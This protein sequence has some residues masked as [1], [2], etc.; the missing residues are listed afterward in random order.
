MTAPDGREALRRRVRRRLL[1]TTVVLVVLATGGVV[2]A[3]GVATSPRSAPK[4]A[5]PPPATAKIV[6]TDLVDQVKVDGTV[7]HGTA[8]ALAGRKAGTLTWLPEQGKVIG[9]GESL[10]AVDAVG[11]KLLLGTTPLYR[12]IRAGVP[13]GPDVTV[14][15]ENLVALGHKDAG[16]PDGEFGAKTERALKKWQKAAGL[17]QTGTL[18]PGDALVLP[19]A[20]RVD[21]VTAQLG[22]A[23][24][25]EL[26]KVTG[27]GRLVTAKIDQARRAYV[28]VGAKVEVVLPGSR[29]VPGKVLSVATGTGKEQENDLVAVIG[30]DDPA[31][32]P[33]SGQ[34]S[35]VLSGARRDGVLAVPVRA[36]VAPAGGG[37]AV[38]VVRDGRRDL[39]RVEPGMFASG[40]VEVSGEGLAE[41]AEVVIAS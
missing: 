39:I 32:V 40:L 1:V 21:A 13:P 6:K 34:V 18:G 17:P 35:V 24:E 33:E 5:P 23:A 8:T 37:Y 15:Q 19:A 25:G 41:G 28:A 7:G 38:E 20:V 11:V 22:A 10:Y 12:E 3:T 36:L 31:A 14:L 27:T 2:L 26:M 29:T 16:P 30:L 9:R 4:S